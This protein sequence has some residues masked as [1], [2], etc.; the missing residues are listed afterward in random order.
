MSITFFKENHTAGQAI[1]A[2]TTIFHI[3]IS[4]G[5]GSEE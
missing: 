4:I 5:V 3:H 2:L 1:S